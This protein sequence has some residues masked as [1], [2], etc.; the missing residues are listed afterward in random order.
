MLKDAL[1]LDADTIRAFVKGGPLPAAK[2]A[3]LIRFLDLQAVYDESRDLLVSTAPEPEPIGVAPERF[4]AKPIDATL[5]WPP[6]SAET[7]HTPGMLRPP[8]RTRAGWA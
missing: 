1:G 3:A 8:P 5:H 4:V 6:F 7:P 2:V